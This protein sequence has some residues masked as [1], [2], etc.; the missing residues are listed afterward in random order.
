Q[1]PQDLKA[2]V[3]FRAQEAGDI[4]GDASLAISWQE[5]ADRLQRWER[6]LQNYPSLDAVI[7]ADIRS[8]AWILFFGID[9]TPIVTNRE[10]GQINPE[11]LAAW[12]SFAGGH[13]PSRYRV[14]I[15]EVLRIVD[16]NGHRMTPA[17]S[18]VTRWI[19]DETNP[20]R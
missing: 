13:T 5:L 10:G 3:V 4:V 12:R 17:V 15:L 20:R 14:T 2:L 6:I 1:L 18:Q 16:S 19:Q 11:V 8:M 7:H 9:N